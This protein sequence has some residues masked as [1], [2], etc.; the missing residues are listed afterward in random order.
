MRARDRVTR[1]PVQ[2]AQIAT[3]SLNIL[4][5]LVFPVYLFDK[6]VLRR[7]YLTNIFVCFFTQKLKTGTFGSL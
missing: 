2:Y 6:T 3:F 4:K 1:F 5:Y 7:F